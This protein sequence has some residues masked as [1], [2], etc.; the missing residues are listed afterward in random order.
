[1]W[2]SM[3][4]VSSP[5]PIKKH[6]DTTYHP[7]SCKFCHLSD[8]ILTSNTAGN[9]GRKGA[10]SSVGGAFRRESSTGACWL[11]RLVRSVLTPP[12]KT[13]LPGGTYPVSLTTYCFGG[14]LNASCFGYLWAIDEGCETGPQARVLVLEIETLRKVS[15]RVKPCSSWK[16]LSG[17]C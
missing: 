17:P 9:L 7:S 15:I 16:H 6:Y 12:W 8:G 3:L 5:H 10:L 11:S 1:M 2:N 14:L 13:S 4:V